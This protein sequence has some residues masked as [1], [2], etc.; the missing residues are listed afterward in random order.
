ME[1]RIILINANACA[2]LCAT[3]SPNRTT[4]THPLCGIG[5]LK[6]KHFCRTRVVIKYN[7]YGAARRR[8]ARR[9]SAAH[10]WFYVFYN[11]R[12]RQ[13]NYAIRKGCTPQT[14]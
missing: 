8:G 10:L 13:R 14:K 4:P 3:P 2:Y 9:V 6:N 7:C 12:A 11:M 5:E 1:Y